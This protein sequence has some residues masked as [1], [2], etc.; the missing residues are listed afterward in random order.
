MKK[1][2][3]SFSMTVAYFVLLVAF[4]TSMALMFFVNRAVNRKINENYCEMLFNEISQNTVDILENSRRMYSSLIE[5][6][7][8]SEVL[9]I[10]D[11]ENYYNNDE[12]SDLLNR[13]YAIGRDTDFYLYF[14][15]NDTIACNSG[16]FSSQRYY[17]VFIEKYS[18]SYEEWMDKLFGT[19]QTAIV[20]LA[21]SDE[22]TIF[23]S[24]KYRKGN[25]TVCLVT[26]LNEKSMINVGGISVWADNIDV[27]ISDLS[28]E[29]YFSRSSSKAG[30]KA[31]SIDD[32]KKSYDEKWGIFERVE[33]SMFPMKVVIA[34][35]ENLTLSGFSA[36]NM[37]QTALCIFLGLFNVCLIAYFLRR[38]RSLLNNIFKK[39][40]VKGKRN[41]LKDVEAGIAEILK[42]NSYY[43]NRIAKVT[44]ERENLI[45]E[46]CLSGVYPKGET[47]KILR[48]D[49]IEFEYRYFAICAFKTGGMEGFYG[50]SGEKLSLKE[51]ITDLI[52]IFQN[53]FTELFLPYDCSVRIIPIE[54]R[55]IALINMKD[56]T[57]YNSR[58]IYDVFH[59]GT[60]FVNKQFSVKCSYVITKMYSDIGQLSEGYAQ[61]IQLLRYKDIMEIEGDL[62]F[63]EVG[64]KGK[65]DFESFLSC[66]TEQKLINFI[67]SFDVENAK[68]LLEHIFSGLS[69]KRLSLE[70]R[71]CI[72]ID[73]ACTLCK[74]PN[75]EFEP[76]FKE[77]ISN[78]VSIEKM[79]KYLFNLTERM[80]TSIKPSDLKNERFASVKS[81]IDTNY[82]EGIDLNLLSINFQISQNY[83]SAGFKKEFGISIPDYI[84][85]IR[86]KNAKLLLENSDRTVKEIAERVG[87]TNVSS[88]NRVFKRF[89]GITPT[90]F[91]ENLIRSKN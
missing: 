82:Y 29:L 37:I 73:I 42:L 27:Y 87:F 56:E 21:C 19:N 4:T 57:H 61:A 41:E 71:Q 55:I 43:S 35:P 44:Q 59:Q 69:E 68:V 50:Q 70:Q 64:K 6:E 7:N 90:V 22:S 28:G 1:V 58:T 84:S 47:E 48:N 52:F 65:V 3:K 86:I 31:L 24:E 39:L 75:N 32:I 49:G 85:K 12:V 51:K 23:M 54:E 63:N 40:G 53:V 76:D 13:L 77:I 8:I 79:K 88:F 89:E 9:K 62:G 14:L 78:S 2:K 15:N 25:Q 33:F 34:Y 11:T 66:D 36:Y 91:K 60:E 81:Y 74:V 83:L 38:N 17:E 46:K 67:K 18:I 72:V 80:C 5:Y 10:T 30:K 45:L 16:F 26:K 20:S